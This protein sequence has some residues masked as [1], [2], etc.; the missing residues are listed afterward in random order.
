MAVYQVETES[1]VYE[2]ETEEIAAQ[3]E[4]MVGSIFGKVPESGYQSGERNILGNIVD[5]PGAAIRSAIQGK[6]YTK[7]AVNPSAVPTFQDLA[8]KSYHEGAGRIAENIP[9]GL[10]RK[11]FEGVATI[12]G[13]IPSAVGMA[14]DI[15]TNPADL[16]GTIIP[17]TKPAQAAG[18]AIMSTKAGQSLKEIATMPIEQIGRPTAEQLGAK[19]SKTVKEGI[20]K[21]VRPSVIGKRT[22]TQQETYFK[23]AES[24]VK[25]VLDNKPNLEIVDRNGNLSVGKNPESL[26]EALQAVGQTR[27]NIFETYSPMIK[28]ASA[29]GEVV[30]GNAIAGKLRSFAAQENIQLSNPGLAKYA[31]DVATR[32]EGKTIPLDVAEQTAKDFNAMLK[33][34]YQQGKISGADVSSAHVDDMVVRMLRNEIADKAGVGDLKRRYGALAE[35]EGDL[36]K[37]AIV[38]GRQ[39]PVGLVDSIAN[40]SSGS[41][42]AGG[43]MLSIMTGNPAYMGFAAKGIAAKV[44]GNF[45]KTANSPDANIAKMFKSVEKLRKIP[46]RKIIT[47]AEVSDSPIPFGRGTVQEADFKE[48]MPKRTEIGFRNKPALP[49][50]AGEGLQVTKKLTPIP[51]RESTSTVP[52]K[53]KTPITSLK[54]KLKS[55]KGEALISRE[56]PIPAN[57]LTPDEQPVAEWIKKHGDDEEGFV[58]SNK[59]AYHGT[60]AEFNVFDE[61]KIGSKNDLGFFGKGIYFSED[62]GEAKSYGK[63][64]IEANL[65][66]KKPFDL[67]TKSNYLVAQQMEMVEKLSSIEEL[68]KKEVNSENGKITLGEVANIINEVKNKAKISEHGNGGFV[69][70][71]KQPKGFELQKQA[72]T[73]EDAIYLLAGDVL[74]YKGI[75]LPDPSVMPRH[76]FGSE[77][78]SDILKKNGFDSVRAENEIVVFSPSQIKTSSDL[79]TL[80]RQVKEKTGT[81][82]KS[83]KD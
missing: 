25:D 51:S 66:L 78:F 28:R 79:R 40:I 41:D 72:E 36:A 15:V 21:A 75:K 62:A 53:G 83:R 57:K 39:N 29:A 10:G 45:I 55:E 16:L 27:E 42:I 64:I 18:R 49:R 9:E 4:K 67:R 73:K 52:V 37:R 8:L 20:E 23:K 82:I 26:N 3:P 35:L 13:M 70:E 61:K 44:A 54:E 46:T 56:T 17:A 81:P 60:D 71:Y 58:K 22:A 77:N 11:A 38:A 1:G 63:N 69:A 30:D 14:A 50:P 32:W 47:P 31:D 33:Q 43:V 7:G 12:G 34:K 19:V 68:V 5:R 80:Y 6:G 74:K 65:N 59:I 48:A 2:V 24:A 76:L